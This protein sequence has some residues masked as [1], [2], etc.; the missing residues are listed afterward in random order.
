MQKK[1]KAKSFE[2]FEQLKKMNT[3]IKLETRV[4]PG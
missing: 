1:T 2:I 3:F 4:F